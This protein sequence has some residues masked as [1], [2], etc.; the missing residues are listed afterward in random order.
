[1]M[2]LSGGAWPVEPE[3]RPERAEQE[4]EQEKVAIPESWTLTPEQKAFIE[5]FS[6]ID[7]QKK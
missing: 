6:Q 4:E 1:M 2:T 3:P 7:N 5:S